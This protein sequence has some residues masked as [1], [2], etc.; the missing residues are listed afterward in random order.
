MHSFNMHFSHKHRQNDNEHNFE[1]DIFIEALH[2]KTPICTRIPISID[3]VAV[4]TNY[5]SVTKDKALE[6]TGL[7]LFHPVVHGCFQ[8]LSALLLSY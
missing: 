3:R 2:I 1:Q 5:P 7:I 8:N 4:F 6:E